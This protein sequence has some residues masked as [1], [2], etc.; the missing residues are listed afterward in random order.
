MRSN[1]SKKELVV[2][3]CQICG[4]EFP[5]WRNAGYLKDDKHV[6]H[7]WCM[8]CNDRTPHRQKKTSEF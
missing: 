5:I 2:Q 3:V 7:L 6:K 4:E 8:T 1:R